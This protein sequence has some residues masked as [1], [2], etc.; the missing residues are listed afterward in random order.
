MTTPTST[1]NLTPTSSRQPTELNVDST[2]PLRHAVIT[3]LRR[4]IDA[5]QIRI[6]VDEVLINEVD[7]TPI[8]GSPN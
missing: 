4:G 7:Y 5:E 1:P 3:L 6:W 8:D 2:L